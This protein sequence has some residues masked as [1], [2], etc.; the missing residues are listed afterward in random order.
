MSPEEQRDLENRSLADS[1]QAYKGR[2]INLRLD[3]YQ[4]GERPKIAEIVEHPGAVT[5]IPVDSEGR[6]I[7]VRQWRRAAKEILYELPAGTLEAGEEPIVCAQREL[8]EE[9]G[10]KAKK[11]VPLG[12]FYTAPGFCSEFLYLFLAEDLFP[13]Q[14]PPDDDESIELAFVPI[15][16]AL[17]M[18]RQNQLRDAKT[19]AGILRYAL[20]NKS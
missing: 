14:L 2:I 1:R 15:E 7:L 5:I 11:I 16:E 19:V 18:I 8:Q 20:L 4:F 17:D 6:I 13:S 10:F 3:T 9:I 12:G